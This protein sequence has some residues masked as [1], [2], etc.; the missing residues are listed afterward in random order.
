MYYNT[1]ACCL[2]W[3]SAYEVASSIYSRLTPRK[4]DFNAL[5]FTIDK[6][7]ELTA[8]AAAVKSRVYANGSDQ[9]N[10]FQR[11]ALFD[12]DIIVEDCRP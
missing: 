1:P 2:Y 4:N 8:Q 11:L 3:D 7:H 6:P 12:V 5:G 9:G 10:G